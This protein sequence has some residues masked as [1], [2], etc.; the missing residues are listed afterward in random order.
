MFRLKEFI[1][2]LKILKT[3]QIKREL[4]RKNKQTIMK[5]KAHAMAFVLRKKQTYRSYRFIETDFQAININILEKSFLK[6]DLYIAGKRK[7]NVDVMR[8]FAATG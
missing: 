8:I 3:P 5:Q 7:E 2:Q 6:K 1:V 4:G